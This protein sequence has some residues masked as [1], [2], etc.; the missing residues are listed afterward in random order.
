[1]PPRA[2]LGVQTVLVC[3]T[4]VPLVRGGAE[5]LVQQLVTELRARGVATDRVSL[6]FKWYPKD[7]ILP[8]AAAWRLL[9]LSESNGRPID[10]IV[11]T[12]FP[13][14]F[15]RHPNEGLLARAP[16]PRRVRAV[17]HRSTA[18][19]A[20]KRST[21]ACAIASWRSTNRCSAEC[22]GLYTISHTVSSAAPEVQ[23]TRVDAALSSAADG[24]AA[25][26]RRIRQLRAVGGA[27]R[28]EQARRSRRSRHGAS[29]DRICGSSS[30]AMAAS[31]R[32]SSRPPKSWALRDRITFAGAVTDDDARRALSRRAVPGL[33]A[34]R[35][36]LRP[37]DARGVPGRQAGDHGPRLGRHAR[38]RARRRQRVRRRTRS[39]QPSPTPSPSSTPIGRAPHHSAAHGRDLA[40]H[41]LLG[42][43][44]RSPAEPWLTPHATSVVIP[45]FDEG[46]GRRRRRLDAARRRARWHEIIVVDDGST[47]DT[48]RHGGGGRREVIRHPYNKGNGASVKTGIRHASGEWILILDGDGQHHPD[49]AVRLVGFLGDYD[50]VVGARS[51]RDTGDHRAP[52]GQRFPER[53]RQLPRRASHSRSHV[54][55]PRGAAAIV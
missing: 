39:R 29:A 6:P 53:A 13:T 46:P 1:M 40:A 55:L 22:R 51:A 18:T 26:A 44:H 30:S 27:A 5:L 19:S 36:G 48:A 33:R 7:E 14:Y 35:R 52:L 41:D 50:L 3:E 42:H 12:K 32:S 45:A 20:T 38:V 4:Q 15:A 11:A 54:G 28:E 23:R 47:D 37:R 25:G 17:R 9:D 31:A 8:H 10:L 24:A 2:C 34:L 21:S 43:G 49:D 16:A